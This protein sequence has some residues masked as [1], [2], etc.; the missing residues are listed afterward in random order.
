MQYTLFL[1]C[2]LII[3]ASANS[4]TNKVIMLRCLHF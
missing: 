2:Y 1:P 4:D 3:A